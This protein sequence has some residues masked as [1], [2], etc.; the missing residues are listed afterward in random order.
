MKVDYQGQDRYTLPGSLKYPGG[1]PP[2]GTILGPNGYGEYVTVVAHRDDRALV[3]V[4]TTTDMAGLGQRGDPCSVAE[5][6]LLA[7][8]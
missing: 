3:A 8:R 7:R 6:T 4:A 2:L 5:R 1:P